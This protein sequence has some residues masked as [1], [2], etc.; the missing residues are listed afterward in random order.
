M[1]RGVWHGQ[2]LLPEYWVEESL[3][4][5]PLDPNYGLLWW[6]NTGR[7]RYPNARETSFLATRAGGKIAWIDSANHLVVAIRWMDPASVD[8][9]TCLVAGELAAER[10]ARGFS[11][12]RPA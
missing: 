8:G 12:P 2:H 11:M 7:T 9:V 1:H 5:C 10:G 6:L 4:P 3:T